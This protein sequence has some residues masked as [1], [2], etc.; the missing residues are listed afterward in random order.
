LKS[1]S[2]EFAC[3]YIVVDAL[4]ECQDRKELLEILQQISRWGVDS[5]RLLVTS[6]RELDI[7]TA[8]LPSLKPETDARLQKESVDTD[9]MAFVRK[10]LT[11]SKWWDNEELRQ[12]IEDVL[13]TKSQGM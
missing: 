12:S 8:L 5:L 2:G 3:T 10:S 1:L 4:D 11:E 6:R 13:L 7:E 9:I